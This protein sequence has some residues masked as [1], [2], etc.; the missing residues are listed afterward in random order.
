[1]PRRAIVLFVPAPACDEIDAIRTRWDPVMCRRIGAHVTLVHD[2]IDHGRVGELVRAVAAS[3]AP[4]TIRLAG[5]GHWGRSAFGVYLDVDDPT[6]GVAALHSHLA[7][8]EDPRWARVRF[9][10]HCTLVHSRTTPPDVAAEAWAALE[11][12]A[13][14]WDVEVAAVDIVELDEASGWTVVERFALTPTLV[15]D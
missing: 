12:F 13:G 15:T 7:E 5:T 4:F 6:G 11:H 10:A 1:M 14:G 2:V 8:L 3:T 9:R